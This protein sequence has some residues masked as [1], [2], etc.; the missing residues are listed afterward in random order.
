MNK[1]TTFSCL[2]SLIALTGCLDDTGSDGDNNGGGAVQ[3]LFTSPSQVQ[4][5]TQSANQAQSQLQ[6]PTQ[7][8]TQ[9]PTQNPTQSQTQNPTQNQT[10]N[11]TQSQTQSPT[12]NQNPNAESSVLA[13]L[14]RS[15]C[16][17]NSA[18]N[19]SLQFDALVSE[20]L[21]TYS[22]TLF[23]DNST[24]TGSLALSVNEFAR[25]SLPG[26]VT[27]IADGDA[28]HIDIIYSGGSM[29][30]S[31][32][33]NELLASQG[34][35]LAALAAADGIAGDINNLTLAEIGRTQAEEYS[36]IRIDD[37]FDGGIEL[38]VGAINA[39]YTGQIPELRPVLLDESRTFI[40]Q[41]F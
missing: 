36:I 18:D 9:N 1:I 26:G 20:N 17:E 38:R 16:E 8:Q 32:G 27:P 21:L 35:D 15:Q 10:Q 39:S 23:I 5:Q 30:A 24:C 12:Q 37:R 29:T 28:Q 41:D 7:N 19:T 25:F 34:T 3:S 4:N 13:G 11:P 31:Q 2:I 14:W 40:K 22:V 33:L 6:N